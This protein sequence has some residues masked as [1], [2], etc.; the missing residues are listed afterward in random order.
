MNI[1]RRDFIKLLGLTAIF[2]NDILKSFKAQE[3]IVI[4]QEYSPYGNKTYAYIRAKENIFKNHVVAMDK[5]SGDIV[6]AKS[7]HDVIGVSVEDIRNGQKGKIQI[8]G[9]ADVIVEDKK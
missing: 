5:A 6:L 3:D 2:P 4:E 8:S 1:N 7:G 9:Y